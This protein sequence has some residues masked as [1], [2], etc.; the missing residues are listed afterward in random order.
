MQPVSRRE[1]LAAA[2]ALAMTPW[3]PCSA[4]AVSFH[5][6]R[7][8]EWVFPES[9]ASGDP[10]PSGVVIWTRIH[11]ARW[12]PDRPLAFEVALDPSF[13]RVVLRGT[14]EASTLGPDTDYTARADLDGRLRPNT[15]YYY[16]FIYDET[17]S[18]VGRCRTLPEA[19]AALARLKLAVVTCND[20]TNGYYGAFAHIAVDSSID[21]VLH[22]GDFIY[23]TTGG[24]GFQPLP[25]ADR[26]IVLPSGQ[27]QAMHLADYRALYRTYRSDRWLQL[28]MECHTWM[29]IWDDHE[30]SNDCYWDYARDTL[31]APD[32]P[33][34]TDPA[35]ANDAGLLRQLKLEAQ[36]AW[37][38]YVPTRATFDAGAT[39]PHDALRI[40][41]RFRFGTLVDLFLT[42]ERTYRSPHPC[43]ES[44]YG[45]RYLNRACPERSAPSSTMLGIPQRDWLIEGLTTSSALWK[46][47]GNEVLAGELKIGPA[48]SG[49]WIFSLDAWDGYAA[50]RTEILRALRDAN[51]R[52]L[53]ALTGDL[54]SYLASYLKVDYGA[55]R[56]DDPANVVGVEFMTPAVTS[57]NIA[58]TL[59]VDP[60]AQAVWGG[61]D[62]AAYFLEPAVRAANPHV[63][64]FNSQHHGYST[65]EFTP[66]GCEYVAYRVDKTVNT[67]RPARSVVRRLRALPNTVRLVRLKA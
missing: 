67:F 18:R 20:F 48:A 26:R 17:A 29:V 59:R 42:D 10:T 21:F 40:Y 11:P 5:P 16:R 30:T 46:A 55:R 14:V 64:F 61:E 38:E 43:G 25:Y 23:E 66:N 12:Q 8:P 1:F 4:S 63:Q 58:E 41:R 51:I 57:T 28:A 22:L 45:G 19:D 6:W 54:H 47:W 9:V 50:E 44:T 65:V 56:N 52:N 53:V 39:H 24:T 2:G 32:H 13:R 60:G 15:Y 31:G 33:Y 7:P 62:S 49:P 27:A 34:Q 3:V 36:R 37:Y 35:Y